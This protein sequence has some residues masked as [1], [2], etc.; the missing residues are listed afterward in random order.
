L[1]VSTDFQA[2]SLAS[3]ILVLREA[4]VNPAIVVMIG[5]P[6][7]GAMPDVVERV[8]ADGTASDAAGAVALAE[9]LVARRTDN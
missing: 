9:R 8:G 7:L 6:V 2:D 1:S 5:G 4:S 3:A